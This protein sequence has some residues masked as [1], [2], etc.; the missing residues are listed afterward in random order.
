VPH[1]ILILFAHPALE[2]SRVNRHLVDAVRGLDEV[3]FHDLYEAYPDFFIDVPREQ[4]LL[5]DHD[6]IVL[7]YPFYWYSTPAIVKQWEDLVLQHGWAYGSEGTALRGKQ[8]MAAITTGGRK[9]AYERGGY[10]RFTVRELMAPIEQTAFLCGI[11]Y[12]PPF[13]AY[14]AHQMTAEEIAMHA[15]E[16]R[17]VVIALR[18]GTLDLGAARRYDRINEHLDSVIRSTVEAG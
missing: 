9:V 2:K 17:R 7:H 13:I 8:L 5:L 3:T 15:D 18:D 11:D 14:G 4:Q 12:L 1:R 16:Y 10:N 6:I